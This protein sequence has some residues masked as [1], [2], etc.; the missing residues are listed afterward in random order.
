MQV[1]R[2]C[3]EIKPNTSNYLPIFVSGPIRSRCLQTGGLN[4]HYADLTGAP[5][6]CRFGLA[7]GAGHP[8]VAGRARDLEWIPPAAMGHR[9]L[10]GPLVRGLSGPQPLHGV[11]AVSA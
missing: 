7:A 2:V 4:H 8:A 11:R 1:V 10:S 6:L 5:D 9:R 3:P